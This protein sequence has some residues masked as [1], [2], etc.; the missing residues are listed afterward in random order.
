MPKEIIRSEDL[1]KVV[2]LKYN[3]VEFP[4]VVT[5]SAESFVSSQMTKSSDFK[6]SDL[7][8]QQVGISELQ[9]RSIE[10][11]I[12]VMALERLQKVE[13]K[14][15]SEAYELGLIEGTQRAFEERKLEFE[16]Q[17]Q[18]MNHLLVE[19]QNMKAK[20]LIENE[21]SFLRLIYE[22]ATKVAMKNIKEESDSI[23]EVLRKV[24][25]DIQAE[26]TVTVKIS[27]EDMMFL[28]GYQEKTGRKL[29]LLDRLKLEVADHLESGGCIVETDAGSMDA[30]IQ[31]R[32]QKAWEIIESR[33]PRYRKSD[34]ESETDKPDQTGEE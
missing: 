15:Y 30:T 3:P 25:N 14:A 8:A 20:V 5:P 4:T 29:D 21:A 31:Q 18:K 33:L 2:V 28:E 10:D 27:P 1:D 7:V 23:L 13:E 12:E 26:D 9:R 11:R 24:V 22:I 16:T 32:V 19:L 34:T 17:Y 6:I